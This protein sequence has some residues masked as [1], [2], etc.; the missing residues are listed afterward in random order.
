MSINIAA[1][2]DYAVDASPMDV[3]MITRIYLDAVPNDSI[4][5]GILAVLSGWLREVGMTVEASGKSDQLNV[6]ILKPVSK[7]EQE[8]GKPDEHQ[9]V[10]EMKAELNLKIANFLMGLLAE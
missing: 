3:E 9:T 7:P 1:H 2:P 5:A 4:N 8:E 10:E 6:C